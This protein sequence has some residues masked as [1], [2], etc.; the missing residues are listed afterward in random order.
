M[1]AAFYG[2]RQWTPIIRRDTPT[3]GTKFKR[4][5]DRVRCGKPFPSSELSSLV[6]E[7]SPASTKNAEAPRQY[8]ATQKRTARPQETARIMITLVGIVLKKRFP[9]TI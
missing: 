9:T 3:N 6:Y 8:L 1:G 2:R 5:R 7:S 4:S